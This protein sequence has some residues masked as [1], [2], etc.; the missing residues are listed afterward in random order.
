MVPEQRIAVRAKRIGLF[1]DVHSN[2]A[3]LQPVASALE[4]EGPL[5]KTQTGR[6]G[7]LDN[8]DQLLLRLCNPV[9]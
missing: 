9:E 1:S 7:V 5:A 4:H 2:L 8:F 3:G 6:S